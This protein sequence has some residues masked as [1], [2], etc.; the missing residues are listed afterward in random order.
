M[1]LDRVEQEAANLL[2]EAVVAGADQ[3]LPD[4]ERLTNSLDGIT[5]DFDT[6][7]T[8]LGL[9]P[10]EARR[11]LIG[12]RLVGGPLSR[13]FLAR[14]EQALPFTLLS[15]SSSS[16]DQVDIQFAGRNT[17]EALDLVELLQARAPKGVTV[18]LT[19]DPA[20]VTIDSPLPAA[21]VTDPVL[22]QVTTKHAQSARAI[23]TR[24]VSGGGTELQIVDLT[25]AGA[26]LFG[27]EIDAT[28]LGGEVSRFDGEDATL[29]VEAIN[30][31]GGLIQ[32]VPEVTFTQS[33]G[34]PAIDPATASPGA[35]LTPSGI[36][37]AGCGTCSQWT[38][39]VHDPAQFSS[40]FDR[41]VAASRDAVAYPSATTPIIAQTTA[42][43]DYVDLFGFRA[44]VTGRAGR[45]VEPITLASGPAH[46]ATLLILRGT[47]VGVSRYFHEDNVDN[48]FLVAARWD[49]GG[50]SADVALPQA[51]NGA[52]WQAVL[53]VR[54]GTAEPNVVYQSGQTPALATVGSGHEMTGI[55][56]IGFDPET[57]SD[58]A[59]L[60]VAYVGFWSLTDAT[61]SRDFRD[62]TAPGI[63]AWCEQTIAG[64]E[65]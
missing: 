11:K 35:W 50:A 5:A 15:A 3:L 46:S 65:T 31:W 43:I 23:L 28:D 27:A 64:L 32:P 59:N 63:I 55:A 51:I 10:T 48:N 53:Y 58:Y 14:I 41:L 7:G 19:I 44:L 2:E 62:N 38:A 20:T 45:N 54:T 37:D 56:A 36:V 57:D 39:A 16:S 47:S 6:F 18:N 52:G 30:L 61:G 49:G 8:W 13:E 29:R 12:L 17:G 34:I 26:D 40:A 25:D 4:W 1:E 21:T 42:G 60:D 33:T 24:N 22:V 9:D